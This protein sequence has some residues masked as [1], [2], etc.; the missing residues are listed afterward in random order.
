M[1]AYL[2]SEGNLRWTTVEPMNMAQTKFK[3]VL[4]NNVEA[5]KI[6][7]VKLDS[8]KVDNGGVYPVVSVTLGRH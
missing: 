2:L 5:Y 6:G 4:H 8:N 1:F 7:E 3:L